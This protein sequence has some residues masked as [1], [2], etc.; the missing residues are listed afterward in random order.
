MRN[1]P[2]LSRV[3]RYVRKG[4]PTTLP[5]SLKPFHHRQSELTIE[6][7]CLLWGIRVVIPKRLQRAVLDMLHEGHPGIA[8]MKTLA[9]GYVWWP[10]L[11]QDITDLVKQCSSCQQ[12]QQAPAV[13]PLHPWLWPDKPWDRVHVD[14]AGPFMGSMF[15]IIVDAHSKWPEVVPMNSTT[16]TQ[17]ITVLRQVFSAYGIPRQLVS[18]NGPQFTSVEFATFCQVNGIK[19][20][21][22]SPYHPASNGLAERFVQSF[23]VA[24]KKAEKDGLPFSQRLATF[25]L[26]YRTTPHA[27]T[28]VAPCV[29]FLGRSVRTRL[30]MLT[31]DPGCAVAEKQ[32]KQKQQHD[33][34]SDSRQFCVG[35]TVWVRNFLG[36]TK[37]VE[38]TV[39]KRVGPLTYLIQ[40][41]RGVTWKRHVDH[42]RERTGVSGDSSSSGGEEGEH[43]GHDWVVPSGTTE[44][45]TPTESV[46]AEVA[47]ESAERTS[48]DFSREPSI[49]LVPVPLPVADEVAE[50]SSSASTRRNPPR[51][52]QVPARFAK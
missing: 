11:D 37:W 49:P 47:A 36:S 12:V 29:L 28:N 15:L 14:F 21:R 43:E 48:L 17:T 23:K 30:D 5:E 7:G 25:L 27:T 3:Y 45:E 38:G 35:Q 24:M 2:L 13:A 22:T 19:H 31:P 4:W 41:P 8:R 52:R 9:R 32:S 44:T 33:Q 26:S 1:D 50:S 46:E 10:G 20:I 51:A 6:G 16:S 39:S 40:L 34:H 42:I 18:D